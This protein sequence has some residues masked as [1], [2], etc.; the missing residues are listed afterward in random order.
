MLEE[1]D[2][3]EMKAQ[4]NSLPRVFEKAT[5]DMPG[6]HEKWGSAVLSDWRTANTMPLSQRCYKLHWQ[7]W[8]HFVC[9]CF[10][11]NFTEF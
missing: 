8:S 5:G 7:Q 11:Q 2:A 3:F 10:Y 6:L 1:T 9:L 4:D